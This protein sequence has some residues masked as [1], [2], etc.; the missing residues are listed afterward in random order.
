MKSPKYLEEYLGLDCHVDLDTLKMFPNAK[1]ITESMGTFNAVWNYV[2]P[3]LF[4][5]RD[6]NV[7]LVSVG[8]GCTPRTAALFAC[9]TAWHCWSIDPRLRTRDTPIKR[10]TC[11]IGKIEDSALDL[12]AFG[13]VV[14]VLVHSHATIKDTLYGIKAKR[15]HI[16]AMPCC[17]PLNIADK[18]FLGYHDTHIWSPHNLLKIWIDA[19]KVQ[20]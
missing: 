18:P 15:L 3:N 9:R 2:C 20:P 1:E 14:A 16:V 7:A 17:V 19:R 12:T 8:D 10:L 5:P 11:I 6:G 13:H 4:G